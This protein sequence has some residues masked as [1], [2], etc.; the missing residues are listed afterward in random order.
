MSSNKY[1]L[2]IFSLFLFGCGSKSNSGI[3]ADQNQ[4][5]INGI[6]VTKSDIISKHSV[7]IYFYQKNASTDPRPEV[8]GQ[9]SGVIIGKK[10]ILT[11]A[12]CFTDPKIKRKNFL[13]V[14]FTQSGDELYKLEQSGLMIN[15][16]DISP[17][18]Y[19]NTSERSPFD[20]AVVTLSK[21]IPTGFEPIEILPYNVELKINDVVI[22]AG[23]GRRTEVDGIYNHRLN[24][25]LGVPIIEDWGTHFIVNQANSSGICSGDSGG[26]TFLSSKG[27]LYLAGI[28]QGL[29]PLSEGSKVKCQNQGV[30]V[31]VQTHKT[32]IL[33][34]IAN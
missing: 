18:P 1:I 23:Y 13:E 9:C 26:P 17:H 21:P 27:K 20:L 24:K 34:N 33:D 10:S 32:W 16:T 12:H 25:S 2:L 28:N 29:I 30:V 11:A 19:Y 6:E 5:I 8:V 15:G 14:Y 7:L 4:S 3:E 22:P 31:K